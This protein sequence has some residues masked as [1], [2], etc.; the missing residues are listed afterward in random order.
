MSD[1]GLLVP[2]F[3]PGCY[4]SKE[5]M[6]KRQAAFYR[7]LEASLNKGEYLDI[8]GNIA[9]VFIYLYYLISKW[10]EKGFENLYEYLIY[11]SELYKKEKS[12]SI[13]CLSWAYD[14]LLGL[15]KYE[16]YLE[17][18]EP[19]E[20]FGTLTERSSL[21]LNIQNWI[22]L[23]ANP[24]DLLLMAGGRKTKF[25]T[26]NQALYKEKV[27]NVFSSYAKE[28]G[29]W[30]NVFK[31][32]QPK[33]SSY[34]Y[35]LFCNTTIG[36]KPKLEPKVISYW[37]AY[38]LVD[39]IQDLSREAEN[40]ARIEVGIPR[41]GEGWISETALFRKLE[42]EFSTTTVIQHGHPEWLGRQHFD[43]WFPNWKIA[44]EY[45]GKQHFEPVDFFGGQHA[46][47]EVV[48]RD[49]RK[50]MLAKQHGVSLYIIAEDDDQDEL[51]C[52]IHKIVEKRKILPPNV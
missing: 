52:K 27:R 49:K 3:E 48:E 6:N 34:Y 20:V 44:V 29:G 2:V 31:N 35:S 11:I 17:K 47:E 51:I 28:Q 24:I 18:S 19:S 23:E 15:K 7:Q 36:K 37:G 12:I 30:F 38:D 13:Y 9:Y 8:E 42:S 21:R 1:A 14:C 50:D 22:G 16:E 10:E 39:K 33:H 40:Q 41:I 43:V 5:N 4:P 25:L 45:H 26:T 32:W 46:F